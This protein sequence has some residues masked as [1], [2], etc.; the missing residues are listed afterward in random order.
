MNWKLRFKNKATL[1]ALVACVVGFLYQMLGFTGIV[2]PISEEMIIQLA[3]AVINILV[4]VGIVVDPTT[5]G[6]SDSQR[7]LGYESCA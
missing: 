7:A 6:I 5:K 3:G 2:V 4:A 1:V